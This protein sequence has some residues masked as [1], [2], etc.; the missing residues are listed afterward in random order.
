MVAMILAPAR[1][2]RY[3]RGMDKIV[4]KHAQVEALEGKL[5][6]QHAGRLAKLDEA[7]LKLVLLVPAER[8][9]RYVH[10]LARRAAQ[11]K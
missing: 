5:T 2:A 4:C 9:G 1:A 11:G 7:S 8:I 6:D 10:E 3:A